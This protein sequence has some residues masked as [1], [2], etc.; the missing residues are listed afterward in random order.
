MV[1]QEAECRHASQIAI[2]KMLRDD[3]SNA[4]MLLFGY[5]GFL[6][7]VC[8][9]PVLLILHLSGTVHLAGLTARVI[10]LTVCKGGACMDSHKTNEPTLSTPVLC[11]KV[12][13]EHHA[14]LIECLPCAGLFDNVLSDYLWARAVM[15]VGKQHAPIGDTFCVCMPVHAT[16]RRF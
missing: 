13:I 8:L 7:A 2:R 10:G 4:V 9:A 12:V 15:L 6:N 5:I 1:H 11:T 3:D 16:V 14:V